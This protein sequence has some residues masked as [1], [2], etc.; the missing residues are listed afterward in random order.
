M[1]RPR[2]RVDRETGLVTR[3]KRGSCECGKV[4]YTSRKMALEAAAIQ[5]RDYG[6][7]DIRP[8][9]SYP[10]HGYHL[11]HPTPRRDREE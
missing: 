7:P 4:L 8:Y 5:R 6:D 2:T 11:G 9:H 1:A 10:C 3:T